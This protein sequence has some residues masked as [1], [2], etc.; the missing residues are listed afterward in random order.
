MYALSVLLGKHVMCGRRRNGGCY[1]HFFMAD[2]SGRGRG[3]HRAHSSQANNTTT[4]GFSGGGGYALLD[5]AS[6]KRPF[7]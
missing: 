3:S 7:T 5:G 2:E 1:A 4:I 6:I